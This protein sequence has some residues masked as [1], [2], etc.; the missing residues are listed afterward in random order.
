M[1]ML[2]Y[3]RPEHHKA[4]HQSPGLR[5]VRDLAIGAMLLEHPDCHTVAQSVFMGLITKPVYAVAA[6]G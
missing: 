3:A 1:W 2:T 5:L 6:G 4:A